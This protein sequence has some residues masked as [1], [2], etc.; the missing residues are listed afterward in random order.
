MGGFHPGRDIPDL[1]GKGYLITRSSS[2]LGEA[3]V[4][5]L[6][7]HTP[8]KIY[9]TARSST[10]AKESLQRIRATSK[11]AQSVD[12]EILEL[13]LA[14]L[15]SVKLAANRANNEVDR[16][17]T[18]QLNAGVASIPASITEEGY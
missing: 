4:A 9:L 14:S 10:R 15:E 5:A 1:N 2:G 8:E 11:A 16:L 13:D 12:I 7:Q 18:L 6:A 3:T 17:D